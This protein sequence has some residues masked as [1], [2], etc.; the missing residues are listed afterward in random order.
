MRLLPSSMTSRKNTDKESK[1]VQLCRDSQL[2]I[3]IESKRESISELKRQKREVN[4]QTDNTEPL[5]SEEVST[6]PPNTRTESSNT[7][8]KATLP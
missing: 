6:L 7:D 2:L 1:I 5:S 3:T 8:Y 4:V